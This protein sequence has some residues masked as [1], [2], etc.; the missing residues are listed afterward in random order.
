MPVVVRELSIK[1]HFKPTDSVFE[2]TPLILGTC[3][4]PVIHPDM[5][6][7]DILRTAKVNA[8][9]VKTSVWMFGN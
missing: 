1:F 7:A 2:F 3:H 6:Q 9:A 8:V 5:P 4:A